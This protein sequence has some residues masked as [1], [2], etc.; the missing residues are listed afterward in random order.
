MGGRFGFL[1]TLNSLSAF[2]EDTPPLGMYSHIPVDGQ[3]VA[4]LKVSFDM[5]LVTFMS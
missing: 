2:P 1:F 4:K 5:E 3:Y